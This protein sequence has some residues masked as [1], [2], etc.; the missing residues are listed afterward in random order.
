MSEKK[1]VIAIIDDE[2]VNRLILKR[3]FSDK[4][5]LCNEFEDG[6]SFLSYL[7]NET[8]D[9]ILLDVMMPGMNGF[10]VCKHIRNNPK[11]FDIPVIIITALSDKESKFKG[12]ELGAYDVITKPFDIFEVQL[13]VKQ[14]IKMRELFLTVRRYN[15]MMKKEI[16]AARKL[17]LS[18]LP[19]SN[20]EINED[21]LFINEYYPC[22]NLGGDFLDYIRLCEDYS[23]V[24]IADVSGHGVASSLITVFLKD[25]FNQNKELFL[26]TLDPAFVLS[27]LNN[28]FLALNF[29]DKYLTMFVAFIDHTTHEITWSSAG[30]NT[31]PLLITEDSI[32][33]LKNEAIAIGW[34]ADVEFESYSFTMPENSMLLCYSDA[35]IEAKNSRGELLEIEGFIN[36]LKSIDILRYDD[37]Q[38]IIQSLLDYSGQ[39]AFNDDLSLMAIKKK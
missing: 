17:Q 22:D 11:A 26:H 30:P 31:S 5:Y 37:L 21:L 19:E 23:L 20:I 1:P 8:P 38:I 12:L 18:M 15:E 9:V 34:W 39:I 2:P 16:L 36:I 33:E 10:E 13:R 25:F 32:T 6:E 24:F 3:S 28:A 29:Q 7:E 27:E 14:Y 4:E 35:A